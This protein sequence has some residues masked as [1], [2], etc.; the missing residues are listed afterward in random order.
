VRDLG[1]DYIINYREQTVKQYVESLT[2]NQGF[3]IVYDTIGG[4]NLDN[5]FLAAR[6][7]GQVIN[8]LAFIPHD[9]TPAFV[10][11]VTIHL[12]NMSLPLLTGVGRERQGEILEEVAKHV[13]AGKLKPLINEQRFTFA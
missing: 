12:E 8:I 9:L 13:D 5:S 3:D 2:N 10:R 11:G 6:N 4:K 1:A 7:N